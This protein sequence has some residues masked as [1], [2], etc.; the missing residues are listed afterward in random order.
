MIWLLP[1][2]GPHFDQASI[3]GVVLIAALVCIAHACTILYMHMCVRYVYAS[4]TTLASWRSTA[5][6]CLS[7]L[8]LT[9]PGN[10]PETQVISIQ[11]EVDKSVRLSG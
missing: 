10:V 4:L 7:F 11:K 3:V 2:A 5:M 9:V 6:A 1:I 8:V